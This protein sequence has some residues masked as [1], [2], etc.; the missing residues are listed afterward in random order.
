[1]STFRNAN[2]L[3][4][5]ER[6]NRSISISS[7]LLSLGIKPNSIVHL[8]SLPDA[9]SRNFHET[10]DIFVGDQV[11]GAANVKASDVIEEM[12]CLHSLGEHSVLVLD[13]AEND[14][15]DSS[16]YMADV[17]INAGDNQ[18][19]VTRI[20]RKAFVKKNK[21]WPLLE[22]EKQISDE[23]MDKRYRFFEQHYPGHSYD[24]ALDRA[25]HYVN[26]GE[27]EKAT[28]L[29]GSLIKGAKKRDLSV[30]L[31]RYLYTLILSDK[32]KNALEIYMKFD[33][34]KLRLGQPF[35]EIGVLLFARNG[36]LAHS[37]K[38]LADSGKRWG[39]S[40]PQ[41]TTLALICIAEKKY[42]EATAHFST[43]LK[44]ARAIKR[45]V[46]EHTLNYLFALLMLWMTRTEGALLYQ[47]K[48]QT[49]KD[50]L[51]LGKL[52]EAESVQLS[53]IQLHANLIMNLDQDFE[54]SLSRCS[55][56]TEKMTLVTKL[57]FL[58]LSATFTD[59]QYFKLVYQEII[60][61]GMATE[62]ALLPSLVAELV[63][64][65]DFKALSLPVGSPQRKVA[66]EMAE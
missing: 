8:N 44:V 20:I 62:F 54:F 6:P 15:K 21:L 53:L 60:G 58:Y 56:K 9:L 11:Y 65:N 37:Y 2:V 63:S 33:K 39:L 43:N 1:M 16:V 23:Q 50:M 4:V 47:R 28:R 41:R 32:H 36:G 18:N 24:I 13:C 59:K 49:V 66:C 5:K 64:A 25:Q 51:P 34:S 19:E 35:D 12:M 42:D 55:R 46:V 22:A 48:Y 38:R 30:V 31:S 7:L 29:L 10:F 14:V 27:L 52:S 61:Q 26:S 45:G 17:L 3:I 57:H 40:L